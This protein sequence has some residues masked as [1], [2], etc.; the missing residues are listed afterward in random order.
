MILR[1][2]LFVALIGLCAYAPVWL[3]GMALFWYAIRYTAYELIFLGVFLDAFYGMDGGFL[4]PV[5]TFGVIIGLLVL[6][7]V[8]PHISVY[9][10]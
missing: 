8:K 3:Y 6:E 9:N 7:S 2:L 5:Y 1:F 10:Q 4:I